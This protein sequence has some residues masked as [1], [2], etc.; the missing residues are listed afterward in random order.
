MR[1][2]MIAASAIALLLGC[3]AA[4]AQQSMAVAPAGSTPVTASCSGGSGPCTATATCPANKSIVSGFWWFVVPDGVG[5]A[6][7]ICGNSSGNCTPGNNSCAFTTSFSGCGQPGWGRQ[8]G[9][10]YA[11]CN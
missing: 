1:G 11:A 6:Y 8:M 10:L 4:D 5:P 3:I 9:F 2:K 7:G